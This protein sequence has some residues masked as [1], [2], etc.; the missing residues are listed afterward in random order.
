MR[1]DNTGDTQEPIGLEAENRTL[2]VRLNLSRGFLAMMHKAYNALLHHEIDYRTLP[3]Y[4]ESTLLDQAMKAN[5]LNGQVLIM[6]YL[7]RLESDIEAAIRRAN[8]RQVK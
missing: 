1:N 7:S 4:M 5:L 3:A 6:D 2:Q 8:M